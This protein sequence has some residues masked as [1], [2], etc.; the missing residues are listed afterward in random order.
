M[1]AAPSAWAYGPVLANASPNSMVP[2]GDRAIAPKPRRPGVV[3]DSSS[4]TRDRGFTESSRLGVTI[5]P[6]DDRS[7]VS[8]LARRA[9]FGLGPGELDAATAL[10]ADTVL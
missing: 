7:A 9:G 10:G 6:V 2:P 1:A 3:V 4:W 8:W 5:A